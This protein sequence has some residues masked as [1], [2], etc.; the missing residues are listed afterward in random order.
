[1]SYL[2][3]YALDGAAAVGSKRFTID[4]VWGLVRTEDIAC[5]S[6]GARVGFRYRGRFP[7]S[8]AARSEASSSTDPHP[9]LLD[10]DYDEALLD[11]VGNVFYCFLRF[12]MV[13]HSP[14]LAYS[15]PMQPP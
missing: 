3:C 4:D 10:S 15:L 11:D 8:S 13:G 9:Q 6:C 2:C 5:K 14:N 7:S 12:D 1:V